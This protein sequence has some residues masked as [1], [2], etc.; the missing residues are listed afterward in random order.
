MNDSILVTNMMNQE[1]TW[2]FIV[3]FDMLE[4]R[5]GRDVN[6]VPGKRALPYIQVK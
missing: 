1:L 2:C 3:G 5:D 4:Y 6:I